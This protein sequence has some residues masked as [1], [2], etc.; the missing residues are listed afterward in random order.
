[1]AVVRTSPAPAA[2]KEGGGGEYIKIKA[3]KGVDINKVPVQY[4]A[5]PRL[6]I[7]MLYKGKGLKGTN[8]A[9]W[10]RN[11]NK[12]FNELIE[13]NPELWSEENITRIL[14]GDIPVVDDVFIKNFTQYAECRNDALRHHHIGGGGQAVAIPESLHTGFG[15]IHNYEKEYGIW[16]NNI[17]PD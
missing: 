9:G 2:G 12:F 7:D 13:K 6:V 3:Y 11:A 14:D 8:A 16:G 5:D 1:L 17:L 15:G 10:E 4:R